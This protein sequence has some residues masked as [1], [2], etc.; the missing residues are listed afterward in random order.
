MCRIA[1]HILAMKCH[2][3]FSELVV[4]VKI[5]WHAADDTD[6]HCQRI[7]VDGRCTKSTPADE[8]I[9]RR[10]VARLYRRTAGNLAT[11][12]C[13]RSGTRMRLA[14]LSTRI[15]VAV[16]IGMA[17]GV[18]PLATHPAKAADLDGG[19]CADLE[20]R[21]AELEAT[22]VRK[23][24]ERVSVTL[25]GW[26]IKIGSFWDDGH[27]TN[28][29]VGDKDTTLSS[30][31]QI[32]GSARIGPGS[33][34][35]YTVAIE[36]PG[37]SCSVGFTESQFN[38]DACAMGDINTLLS[39]MWIKSDKYGTLNWGQASQPTDNVGILP[40]LSG[41]MIESNAVVFDGSGMRVR[42]KGAKNSNDLA[43]EFVWGA[44][45]AC[46]GAG[47]G[48]GA[49][50][51]GYPE[52]VVRYDSPTWGGFSASSSYGF[53][54]MWDVSVQYAGDWNNIKVIAAAGFANVT[55]EGCSAVGSC[56]RVPVFGGGGT[57]FQGF[58]KDTD[59]WQVGASL[60][61]VPTGLLIHGYWQQE[62]NN[63]TQLTTL[64][65]KTPTSVS[66]SAANE[67]ETWFI[68]AGIK[69]TW[70]A[71]GPTVLWGEWGQYN[72]MFSFQCGGKPDAGCPTLIP[73][74]A[75]FPGGLKG[76]ITNEQGVVE[77]SEVQRWGLGVLQNIDAAALH[78]FARWQRL[79]IDVDA[80]STGLACSSGGGLCFENGRFGK[81]I[82][83]NFE[84]L[85]IY[86]IGGVIFF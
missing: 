68:K 32:T 2:N 48:I 63:G 52:N 10:Q 38:D 7:G 14:R 74:S 9:S 46:L 53:D 78:V 60:M 17:L 86:K 83:T 73:T 30:H 3:I 42:V 37:Q 29:Y 28:F 4:G 26:V 8:R 18:F 57:P 1:V 47:F 16:S 56:T 33:S 55:D 49:D 19:C 54:D 39:Y 20:E 70:L 15:A 64:N 71:A 36:F 80:R 51:N 45:L 5:L 25:S 21:V 81:R 11:L 61:H 43:G 23:G 31:V 77:G 65:F 41:T 84:D 62:D 75:S 40:D 6:A 27:E 22:T 79:S 85:D 35:G 82:N 12:F 44:F 76:D 72:D 50:C 66:K 24:N 59:V 67:N 69:R 34:A 58:R 13:I